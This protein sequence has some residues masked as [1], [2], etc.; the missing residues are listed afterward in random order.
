MLNYTV[1]LPDTRREKRARIKK[2]TGGKI[3]VENGN[4]VWNK[5]YGKGKKMNIANNVWEN[6][7]ETPF[8]LRC[9]SV[10]YA[11]KFVEKGSIK[12]GTPRTWEQDALT[13]NIIGRGD[14]YE[15][16]IA[17][18][19]VL[20]VDRILE[21]NNIYPDTERLKYKNRT[22]FKRTRSMDL[23][24]FCM[25]D[26]NMAQFTSPKEGWQKVKAEIPASYFKDFVEHKS[27]VEIEEILVEDRPAL[28]VINNPSEFRNRI[29]KHLI[30]IGCKE[31]EILTALVTYVD[32]E[33]YGFDGWYDFAQKEPKELFLKSSIFSGQ[34]EVRIIVNTNKK[35]VLDILKKPIEIGVLSDIAFLS[36]HF[37][38]KGLFVEMNENAHSIEE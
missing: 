36:D 9:T 23:P 33:K 15:G 12:F 3:Y 2:R 27:K 34:S 29:K 18:A 20:N 19:D 5:Y 13:S 16:A 4:E 30:S 22:L 7:N 32:F 31:S 21:L 38:D 10:K 25:Y 24:C 11:R 1:Q 37:F 6:P 14:P 8:F 28:I 35:E 17:F 26:L